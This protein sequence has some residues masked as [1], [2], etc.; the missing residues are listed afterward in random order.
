MKQSR[1]RNR[2]I[3]DLFGGRMNIF[4][5]IKALTAIKNNSKG[6]V[7]F[8]IFIKENIRSFTIAGRLNCRI[9]NIFGSLRKLI[10]GEIARPKHFLQRSYQEKFHRKKLPISIK[11]KIYEYFKPGQGK[12]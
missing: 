4:S 2:A 11:G 12:R 8:A 5:Q 1:E 6:F 10:I 9:K 7:E 3:K